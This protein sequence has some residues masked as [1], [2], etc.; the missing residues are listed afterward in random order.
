MG[1]ISVN[2]IVVALVFLLSSCG[3]SDAPTNSSGDKKP[4]KSGDNKKKTDTLDGRPDRIIPP[5]DEKGLEGNWRAVVLT[6]DNSISAF[7]N[8]REAVGSF[9]L[10]TGILASDIFHMSMSSSKINGAVKRTSVGQIEASLSGL[11]VNDK[12]LIHMTSHGSRTGF[13]LVNQNEMGPQE[14]DAILTRTCGDR[15]TVVLISACYSG[16]FSSS[17]AM[18]KPNRIILTAARPDR[19]SFGC[20]AENQYT[21]WDGCLLENLPHATSWQNL[22]DSN[23]S[24]ISRKES[25]G[26]YTPSE[27]Q[28]FIGD[29]V[30]AL[31]YL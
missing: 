14:F 31:S 8:A 9:F 15:P 2:A 25:G 21:Y 3:V 4:G 5:S 24:C 27:P 22:H 29:K 23:L 12:C 28:I 6:G 26:G 16:I 13:L 19:T 20:S 7:D 30:K 1:Q 10:S 17:T 11:G 18:R